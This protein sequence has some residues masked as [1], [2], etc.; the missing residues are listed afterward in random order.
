MARKLGLQ[1]NQAKLL[2]IRISIMAANLRILYNEKIKK[3]L[4]KEFGYTNPMQV[5]ELKMIS[6]N[7]GFG[8]E[9]VANPKMVESAVRDLAL[10]AGQQP[11]VTKSKKSIASFKLRE[12][13]PVGCKVTLRGDRM[14]EFMER[15]INAALPR[16]RD[17]RGLSPKGFD[18][19]GNYAMGLKEQLVFPEIEYDKIDKIRGMDIIIVTTASNDNEALQLLKAFNMPFRNQ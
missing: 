19:N 13:Q 4:Q 10:I 11:V 16:V 2:I 12:G 3:Q 18:G 8:K 17:F 6:I 14:Y 7:M 9:S 5:A 1:K 15:L